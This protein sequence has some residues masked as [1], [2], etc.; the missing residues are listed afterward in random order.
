MQHVILF[1]E[2]KECEQN[3]PTTLPGYNHGT[4]LVLLLTCFAFI[5]ILCK[6]YFLRSKE[7][8]SKPILP[9][10]NKKEQVQPKKNVLDM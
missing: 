9:Y 10:V 2:A 4:E 6:S 5:N 8:F 7:K 3:K 1:E